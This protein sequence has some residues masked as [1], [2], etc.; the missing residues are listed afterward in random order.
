MRDEKTALSYWYPK[1]LATG[2][3]T[4]ETFIV[5]AGCDLI[6][7]IDGKKPAGYASFVRRLKEAA[8]KV[9]PYPIFLR[10]GLTSAKHHWKETCY[11]PSE[12]VLERH[13]AAI[14]EFS[15]NADMMGLP[16]DEWVLRKFIPMESSFTAFHGDFPVNR[17]R[18]YFLR[19]GL[20]A[21]GHP[22]WPKEALE[23]Q[24]PREA[25]ADDGDIWGGGPCES[26]LP[27]DWEARLEALNRDSKEDARLLDGYATK[28]AR[29]FRGD[30]YWSCD[31]AKAA[32]GR[33]I[34]VDMAEG[35]RSYHWAGCKNAEATNE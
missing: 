23:D 28:V 2:V 15:E 33:W 17:E 24:A 29:A 12:A 6:Y 21:C 8:A 35:H 32:D 19:S 22:Y 25:E 34:C 31:F 26:K 9:G 18:R 30:G 20:V 11:V 5:E 27:I 1:L 14:V 16:T 3:P 7:L 10:T 13:V 4:P